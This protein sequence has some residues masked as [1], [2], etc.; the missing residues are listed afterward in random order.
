M[1]NRRRTVK[2][3]R[4]VEAVEAP[5]A[6]SSKSK[7]GGGGGGRPRGARPKRSLP[8]RIAWWS[9]TLGLVGLVVGV[10]V[11]AGIFLYYGSD[12]AMPRIDHVGDYHP[13][14]VTRV[15]DRSG[16]LIGE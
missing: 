16:E 10:G 4:M 3:P 7:G 13:K 2:T 5:P 6:R 8:W 1:A 11:I 14:V 12:P 9:V 15:L